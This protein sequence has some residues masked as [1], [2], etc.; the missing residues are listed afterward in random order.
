MGTKLKQLSI[1]LWQPIL[2][3]AYAAVMIFIFSLYKI[4]ALDWAVGIGALSSS[5]F[6]VI[7]SPKKISAQNKNLILSYII[8]ILFALLVHIIKVNSNLILHSTNIHM[9]ESWMVFI[10][11]FATLVMA[12]FSIY[13]P[14]AAGLSMVL[15]VDNF[16]M[17][18]VFIICFGVLLLALINRLLHDYLKD[19]F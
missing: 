14:P 16:N 6:I 18:T 17:P 1:A 3:A 19:L 2:L 4:S 12:K 8:A 7:T 9:N 10:I 15:A 11:L 13:H 5:A